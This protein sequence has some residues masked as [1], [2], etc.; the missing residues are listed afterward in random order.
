MLERQGNL[1]SA[2]GSGLASV[3]DAISR[4]YGHSQSDFLN[5]TLQGQKQAR[6]EGLG[7]FDAAQKG[8]TAQTQAGMEFGKMDPTSEVSKMTQEAFSGPLGKL[9]YSKEAVAKMP[10]SQIDML[11]QV[12]LKYADIESQKELKQATLE[13]QSMLGNATIR[14]QQRERTLAEEKAKQ[15]KDVEAAKHY[16]AD[17][18]GALA[19]RKRLSKGAT[20]PVETPVQS[21][22][23]YGQDVLTYAK[24]H[25]ITPE[26]AQSIKDKRTGGQ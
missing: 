3:G 18:L 5:Q 17:P 23:D 1:P 11:S 14:N 8:T 10:A 25:G 9:G 15:E 12:V 6:E 26:Q 20:T 24:S 4:G 22:S 7:A 13:L 21:Q 16:F 2:I 19:A